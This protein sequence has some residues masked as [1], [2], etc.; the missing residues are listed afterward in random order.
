MIRK[1]LRHAIWLAYE[2]RD[3]YGGGLIENFD[4]LEIDHIIPRSICKG[5]LEEKINKYG[6]T[7]GFNIHSIENL[8]P[9]SKFHNRQ[10]GDMVF[11]ESSERYFLFLAASKKKKVEEELGKIIKNY[12]SREKKRFGVKYEIVDTHTYGSNPTYFN[13]MDLVSLTAFLPSKFGQQGSCNI[14]FYE[15]GSMMTLSHEIVS[16]LAD[17]I[18]YRTLEECIYYYYNI[19]S[20]SGFVSLGSTSIHLKKDAYYQLLTILN[21]FLLVYASYVKLYK[22]FFGISGLQMT[23]NQD[24]YLL[25]EVSE[26]EWQSL[27][28]YSYLHDMRDPI[29]DGFYFNANDNCL[30]ALDKEEQI[31][32]FQIYCHNVTS[33]SSSKVILWWQLPTIRQRKFIETGKVWTAAMVLKWVEDTLNRAEEA[34][35]CAAKNSTKRFSLFGFQ[36]GRR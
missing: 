31:I 28:Q 25:K 16:K 19:K 13:S 5:D 11:D 14:E 1:E 6:L 26:A 3:V 23:D 8:V 7:N 24:L 4:D 17:K 21:D 30:I 9:T 18:G 12:K 33:M 20:E 10:K 36:K 27:I 35:K 15:Y 32:R 2:K 22:D 29:G 34:N